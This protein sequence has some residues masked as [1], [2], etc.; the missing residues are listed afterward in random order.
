MIAKRIHYCWF[1]RGKMPYSI[2]KCIESWIKY[3]PD[4][5]LILWNENNFDLNSNQYIK[6]AYDSKKFAFV[7]DYVRLYALYEHGGV[8]M[9]TDVEVV[10]SLDSFLIHSAFIGCENEFMLGTSIMA[11]EAKHQWIKRLLD[12]YQNKRFILPDGSYDMTANTFVITNITT[13]EFGWIPQNTYQ[14][15]KEDLHIYPFDYFCAKSY[16][17][18]KIYMTKNTHTIHHFSSSWFS[19][20]AK[21]TQN[22]KRIFGPNITAKIIATKKR[23]RKRF[24][25]E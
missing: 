19:K 25:K 4:Y 14:K 17:D 15:L 10:K 21:V 6:E 11:S 5:E 8:Y 13:D 24:L 20:K 3:L 22:L 2:R 16:E 9:D 1:G 18:G 7:T 23:F 12:D